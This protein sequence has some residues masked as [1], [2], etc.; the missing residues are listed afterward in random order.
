MFMLGY[1][2]WCDSS[3]GS[4]LKTHII[5]SPN[6]GPKQTAQYNNYL[7]LNNTINTYYIANTT[8]LCAALVILISIPCFLLIQNNSSIN[9]SGQLI[10]HR[11]Y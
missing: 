2:L 1:S 3:L 9:Y 10:M 8:K 5:L 6:S 4:W 11:K 7:L